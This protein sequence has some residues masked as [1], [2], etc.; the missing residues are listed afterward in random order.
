MCP[1]EQ[2]E[3]DPFPFC[4]EHLCQ[5]VG[6]PAN[7]WSNI[8]YYLVAVMLW[9]S[10]TGHPVRRAF[11]AIALVQAVGSTL[12]HMS[13]SLWAKELDVVAMLLLSALCLVLGL[14]RLYGWRPGPL[15][16]LFI[17]LNA[18]SYPTITLGKIGGYIFLGQS[19]LAVALEW[20]R[21]RREALAGLTYL[22][23]VLVV[24]PV[25]VVLNYMD[26]NGPLCWPGNH[27]FTVHGLW[28]LM[29][30]FCI[31]RIAQ[32]YTTDYSSPRNS[33]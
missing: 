30:A 29:T 10:S 32:Y 12:F 26:Q 18:L 14:R 8:G 2:Y 16:A 6:Q 15:G 22:R 23:Q 25:A 13:G 9:R 31:Y 27:V 11:A 21:S 1:W 24:F 28:H 20:R 17:G 7:T 4:E 19:L 33:S 3:K 5:L